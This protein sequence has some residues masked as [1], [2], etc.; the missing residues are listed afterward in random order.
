L[1]ATCALGEPERLAAPEVVPELVAPESE[2]WP[3]QAASPALISSRASTRLGE[4]M[5]NEW[6]M[7]CRL[8]R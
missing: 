2:L 1:A 5:G 7:C 8:A 6:F 3:P 4:R